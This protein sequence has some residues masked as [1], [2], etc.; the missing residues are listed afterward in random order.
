MAANCFLDDVTFE[1][2]ATCCILQLIPKLAPSIPRMEFRLNDAI[3]LYDNNGGLYIKDLISFI[4]IRQ[5]SFPI[6]TVTPVTTYNTALELYTQLKAWRDAC[7]A[8]A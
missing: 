2:D 5:N 1:L 4:H 8:P 7:C 6:T 3:F